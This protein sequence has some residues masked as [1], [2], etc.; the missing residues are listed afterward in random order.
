MDTYKT[1]VL[2]SLHRDGMI[3]D[4]LY[5]YCL[6]LCYIVTCRGTYENLYYR[7]QW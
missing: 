3:N 4:L 2:K 6:V 7:V 1:V 5:S